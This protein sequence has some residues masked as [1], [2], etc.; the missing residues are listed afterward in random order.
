MKL[1]KWAAWLEW[2]IFGHGCTNCIRL[3]DYHHCKLFNMAV[4]RD[5]QYC[6]CWRPRTK[7]GETE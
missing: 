6:C 1:A 7:P 2:R 4:V 3:V 5:G